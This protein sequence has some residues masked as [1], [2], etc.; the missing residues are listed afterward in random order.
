MSY[1]VEPSWYLC[2]QRQAYTSITMK[3]RLKVCLPTEA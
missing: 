1:C 3:M 2:W